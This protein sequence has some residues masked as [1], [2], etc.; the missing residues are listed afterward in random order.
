MMRNFLLSTLLLGALSGA[1]AQSAMQITNSTPTAKMGLTPKDK[2]EVGIS[3]GFYFMQGDLEYKPSFSVAGHVR[4]ALDHVFSVRVNGFAGILNMQT[5]KIAG[6]TTLTPY[7]YGGEETRNSAGVG[8]DRTFTKAKTT[9]LSGTG[10]LV[11]SLNA[12]RYDGAVR[13]FNPYIAVGG[14]VASISTQLTGL[15]KPAG[16]TSNVTEGQEIEIG[17]RLA[18]KLN[19]LAQVGG[20]ISYRIN[21]KVNV[22]LEQSVQLV[23]GKR[24]DLIDGYQY[25]FRDL[26]ANTALNINFNIG[27]KESAEPLYWI[28]PMQSIQNDIAELK[29]R[30]KFDPTDSDGDGVIDMFDQEKNTVAGNPVDTRGI[31]LDSDLDGI[32]NAKD[33]EPY[34]PPGYKIN[35]D[36]IAQVPKPTYA[37][38]EFVNK[39]IDDKLAALKAS[40]AGM[41]AKT[42]SIA[43]WFLPMIHYDFNRYD[44]KSSEHENL[45]QVATVMQKNPS[46]RIVVQ[47]HTDAIAKDSYNKALSYNRAQAAINYL[48]SKYGIDRS[49]LVLNY[50]GED[51]KLVETGAK[52]YV[53]RRVEF[54]VAGSESDMP[55]PSGTSKAGVGGKFKGN[56]AGY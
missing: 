23:F 55:A 18:G 7:R 41:T 31:T 24:A 8:D 33:K 45:A 32:P 29:A 11:I 40:M 14:G 56:K 48:V 22:G 42:T 20:G 50:G 38:E 34:S 43:D 47:G 49:R 52:N 13:R 28:N 16:S 27:K 25:N 4:K 26:I 39:S 1:N 44:I 3:P 2:W 17:G 10:D 35:A 19:P 53:N 46:I 9:I 15:A 5:P 51:T 12:S 30:P 54:R 6:G 21:D 37:T 36:G